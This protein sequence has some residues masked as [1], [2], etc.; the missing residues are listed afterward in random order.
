MPIT[1]TIPVASAASP[2]DTPN[3][4]IWLHAH[5]DDETLT[6]GPGIEQAVTEGRHVIAVLA[7]DGRSSAARSQTGLS[8][9]TFSAARDKELA[10]AYFQLGVH[11]AF[12][13]GGYDGGLTMVQAQAI[14]DKWVDRFPQG[15][16]RAQSY[17]D[18]TPDHRNLG[19]AL[20]NA[21]RA[22]PWLDVQFFLKRGDWGKN[23][24]G[25]RYIYGGTRTRNA[26]REYGVVNRADLR[27]GI[28]HL[29]VPESFDALM[30]DTRTMV[31]GPA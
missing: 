14:V 17:H 7:T 16:F 3:P 2:Q 6:L 4:T 20:L 22:R 31:H 28:G 13:E 25:C 30:A 8:Y 21:W 19:Q 12:A 15:S 26:A 27:Y 1:P 9:E 18:S 10:A 24:A 5:Q 11:Q 23:P 29:S